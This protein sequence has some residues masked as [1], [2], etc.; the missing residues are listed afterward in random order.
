M[1]RDIWA[2]ILLALLTLVT[3]AGLALAIQALERTRK[4]QLRTLEALV[5]RLNR[6]QP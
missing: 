1:R 4:L 5:R 3:A 6:V 2:R